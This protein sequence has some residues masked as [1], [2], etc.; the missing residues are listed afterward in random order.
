MF[1]GARAVFR[2][3]CFICLALVYF[4]VSFPSSANAQNW[5]WTTEVVDTSGRSTSLAVDAEGNVHISYGANEG[6]K[7]GF[8]PAGDNSKWFTMA[9]GG[10][11]N[12]T[13]LT[14]DGQGNPHICSTYMGLPLRYAHYDGKQWRTQEIAT[15]DKTSVQAA[16]GVVVSPE[17][18]P[19]VSWY[20]MPYEDPNY[21]HIKYAVLRN[22]VWLMRTLD[23]DAQSGKWHKMMLDSRGN[24]CISYDA[25]VKGLLKLGCWDGK[26]WE[27]HVVDS[28]GAH[29]SDYSLGMGSSLV[30]D[31]HGTPHV[32]YYTDT[33]MRHAW[34][35][36]ERWKIE[37]VEKITPSGAFFDYRSSILFDRDGFLHISYED[38]GVAKHAYW[39]GKQWL[40][41]VIA[42]AGGLPSR[43]SSMAVDSKNNVL[44]L[45]FRDA[46]DGSLK[47]AVGRKVD[48]SQTAMGDSKT[49]K[50]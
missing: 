26:N 3:K 31:S 11:V 1:I 6:L 42:P 10:G 22:G 46:M 23:F 12:Y 21:K 7:Y 17:G 24:P 36:G 38:G 14:L 8:R 50:N 27:I 39:D 30:F 43:F 19:Q 49:N 13:D 37:T 48:R 45:A 32:S 33:E 29:G 9:L 2:A 28:R 18:T 4:A 20:R 47:V 35:D 15:E 40:V 16:C 5:V 25:F 34:Q 44:F 41:Q